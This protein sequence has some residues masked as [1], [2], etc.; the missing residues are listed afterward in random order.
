M[1]QT[2]V[3]I[4]SKRIII[5]YYLSTSCVYEKKTI[6]T[7]DLLAVKD[8]MRICLKTKKKKIGRKTDTPLSSIF[9]VGSKVPG[10]LHFK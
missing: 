8:E 4:S 2:K 7:F 5:S 1:Y 3:T 10:N 6:I 9:A